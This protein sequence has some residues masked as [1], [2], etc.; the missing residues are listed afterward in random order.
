MLIVRCSNENYL[1][2]DSRE[3]IVMRS[4]HRVDTNYI[5][6]GPLGVKK[7]N[8]IAR[9]NLPQFRGCLQTFSYVMNPSHFE[10]TETVVFLFFFFIASSGPICPFPRLHGL[11]R[12][13]FSTPFCSCF[14]GLIIPVPC[15]SIGP[16]PQFLY[17]D[18]ATQWTK[19]RP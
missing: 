16:Q 10:V 4:L 9:Y 12:P 5:H 11:R 13:S 17:C 6:P 3:I 1:C 2:V 19:Q 7:I 14:R 18:L 8:L 15:Y